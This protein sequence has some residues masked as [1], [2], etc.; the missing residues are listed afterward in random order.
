MAAHDEEAAIG[1]CVL[2]LLRLPRAWRVTVVD[3][4]ST[5]G[6]A[7]VLAALDDARLR[8]LSVPYRSRARAVNAGL[9]RAEADYVCV[10]DADVRFVADRFDDLVAE[11]SAVP[12]L[13]L[14]EDPADVIVRAVEL[15]PGFAAPRNAFLF[16]RQALPGL[17]FSEVYR[18]GAGGEDTDLAIRLLRTGVR[19]GAVAGGY[20]HDRMPGAMGWRRRLHFHVWNLVTYLRHLDVPMCRR[21][22]AGIVRHPLRR[23]VRSIREERGRGRSAAADQR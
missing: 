11:L 15:G 6:T 12:F 1:A 20:V 22:L 18:R 8:V 9:R 16:S 4:A 7:A 23:A 3:D 21:R 5:D 14:T 13:M 10:V 19:L 17:A 2:A